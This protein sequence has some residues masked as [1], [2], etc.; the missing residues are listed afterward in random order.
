MDGERAQ[1]SIDA[2]TAEGGFQNGLALN[3]RIVP[4]GGGEPFTVPVRQIAPGQYVADFTPEAEGVYLIRM[5]GEAQ[6]GT[7]IAQ[8]TGWVMSYS[9][10][11]R[12]SGLA[13]GAA[14]LADIAAQTGGRSLI[15]AP[16]EAF[17][18]TLQA[19]AGFTP[20]WPNLV[21]LAMLL[22][23]VD[24]AVRRLIITRSDLQRARAALFGR[25]QAAPE[26]EERMSALKSA[27]ARADQSITPD[28]VPAAPAPAPVSSAPAQPAPPAAQPRP[29]DSNIA[30]E[31]LKRRRGRD[32]SA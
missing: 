2:R 20:V 7:P 12:A 18:H 9:P 16:G 32:E 19:R 14:L 26:T 28:A 5:Y 11:Y 6:D 31:L 17:A 27:K 15:D 22:L 30:G 10:E 3:A 4:P 8:T 25:G 24:I 23:P 21:L 13:D 1:V 29:A